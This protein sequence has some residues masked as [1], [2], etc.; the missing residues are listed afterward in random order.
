MA[1]DNQTPDAGAA[2]GNQQTTEAQMAVDHV[3]LKDT[4]FEALSPQELDG[5]AGQPDINMNLSQRTSQINENRWEVILTV[6]ITAKQG[7]KT[8]FVCE[9]Q[10]GGIFTF[11][12]FSEQ[13]MP[14]VINV[15]C[16]NVLFP[17]CRTQ[18]G[19]LV[20]AGGFYMPPMQAI[21]FEAI[22]RQ[23]MAEAQAQA[24]AGQG[25]APADGSQ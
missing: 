12:G 25:N 24:E 19:T 1:D 8:A 22:F 23:R 20:G 10:Y 6:T 13:Q 9:V 2:A 14:Y 15:L 4:S 5:N 18:V 21:N 17:Y 11:A 7:E 16:P 3:F